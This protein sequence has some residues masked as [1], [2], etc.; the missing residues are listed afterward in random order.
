MTSKRNTTRGA[1]SKMSIDIENL[2][3]AIIEQEIISVFDTIF[4][5][6]LILTDRDSF[7]DE[8]LAKFQGLKY[9][10]IGE[11]LNELDDFPLFALISSDEGKYCLG[12]YFMFLLG[13]IRKTR[14]AYPQSLNPH[15]LGSDFFSMISFIE[16]EEILEWLCSIHPLRKLTCKMIDSCMNSAGFH[17]CENHLN[18]MLRIRMRLNLSGVGSRTVTF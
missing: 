11:V 14:A 5:T 16:K 3:L 10:S 9:S 17:F 13:E 1:K 2:D 7:D 4:P 15:V 18:M 6:R 8:S 12:G